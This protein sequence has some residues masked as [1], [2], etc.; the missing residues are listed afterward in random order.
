MCLLKYCDSPPTAFSSS[1]WILNIHTYTLRVSPGGQLCCLCARPWCEARA[2][3]QLNSNA[4][5]VVVEVVVVVVVVVALVQV[6]VVVVVEIVVVVVVVV[7]VV[8]LVI[9]VVVCTKEQSAGSI[10]NS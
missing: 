8:L 1:T 3:L 7:V 10:P 6:V 4:L 2:C 9:L 5:A